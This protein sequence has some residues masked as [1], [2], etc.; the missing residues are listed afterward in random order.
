M[1]DEIVSLLKSSQGYLS[2]EEISTKFNISRAAIWKHIEE[3]RKEGYSIEGSSHLGYRIKNSPDKLFPWE[4]KKGLKTKIFGQKIQHFETVEST[5]N[6][7]FSSGLKGESEGFIVCAETQTAGKGRMGRKWVSPKGKGVYFSILLKPCLPIN[8]LPKLTLLAAVSVCEAI[9]SIIAP[10]KSNI[11]WP[12]DILVG[13]RKL[14]GIL[15]ELNAEMDRANF[16]VIGIGINVNSSL[17]MLPA[18]STSMKI[19]VKKEFSRI[20]VL[21][22]VL[23]RLEDWYIKVNKEGFD[24]LIKEWKTL[25]STIGKTIAFSDNNKVFKAK[26]ID[27]DEF[28]RLVLKTNNGRIIKKISGDVIQN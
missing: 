25:N 7:A 13:K 24:G 4:V 8:E 16:I 23:Y 11:K 2:G 1:R 28:G 9:N 12:N 6:I 3:L 20:L 17:N 21:Q 5:M 27:I 19:E 10:L 26:A 14:A 18:G 22:E 15:T